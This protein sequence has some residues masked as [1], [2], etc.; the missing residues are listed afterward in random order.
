MDRRKV[1]DQREKQAGGKL[2]NANTNACLDHQLAHT[3]RESRSRCWMEI[4]ACAH[5]CQ[6]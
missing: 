5:A 1:A 4:R 2:R 6:S 3:N